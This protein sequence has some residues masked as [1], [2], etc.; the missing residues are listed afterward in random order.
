MRIL[1]RELTLSLRSLGRAWVFLLF[2]T[3]SLAVGNSTVAVAVAVAESLFSQPPGVSEPEALVD[4]TPDRPSSF[5]AGLTAD[6]LSALN[7]SLES[8]ELSASWVPIRGALLHGGEV[9]V[10]SAE[11]VSGS[12]F[13][14]LRVVPALGRPIG[15]TD[16]TPGAT[17]VAVISD[18]LWRRQFQ[19]RADVIGQPIEFMGRRF[20]VIGVTPPLFRGLFNG[21]RIAS[22]LWVPLSSLDNGAGIQSR[23]EDATGRVLWTGRLRRGATVGRARAEIGGRLSLPVPSAESGGVGGQVEDGRGWTV[24]PVASSWL[25]ATG[26]LATPAVG[27][28]VVLA[29]GG[30]VLLCA[31][32]TCLVLARCWVTRSE[33]TTRFA[34]GG[35]LARVVI[36]PIAEGALL[37]LFGACAG[38]TVT[39]VVLWFVRDQ[40][41]L[42][43]LAN[44]YSIVLPTVVSG[45]VLSAILATSLLQFLL[46]AGVPAVWAWRRLAQTSLSP[47]ARAATIWLPARGI[48]TVQLATAM[49]V[50][51]PAL[52]SRDLVAAATDFDFGVHIGGTSILRLKLDEARR[53]GLRPDELAAL[54]RSRMR[55]VPGVVSST[56]VSAVPISPGANA[57]VR[58]WTGTT[59]LVTVISVDDSTLGL[60]GV[61]RLSGRALG[62]NGPVGAAEVLVSRAASLRLFGT[63]DAT[64]KTLSYESQP[65]RADDALVAGVV[66]D[67]GLP[68]Q[69]AGLVVYRSLS[70]RPVTDLVLIARCSDRL[71]DCS[72]HVSVA[73]SSVDGAQITAVARPGWTVVSPQ[74][75]V[76]A[77]LST[78]AFVAGAIVLILGSGGITGML[79]QTVAQRTREIAV[80]VAIGASPLDVSTVVA[81]DLASALVKGIAG[82]L[83]IGLAVSIGLWQRHA[84]VH[85]GS[86]LTSVVASLFVCLS[87]LLISMVAASFVAWRIQPSAVLKD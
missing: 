54:L 81:S 9:S 60:L 41:D 72:R 84:G 16:D 13:S 20:T 80:R 46:V 74:Y 18:A 6:Q 78:T 58:S 36:R 71:S 17:P 57:S 34:L 70:Q 15:S 35:S 67:V 76:L 33:F 19:G 4:I 82:G 62:V 68:G 32:I 59:E 10:V 27:V 25:R 56:L 75:A 66:A 69:Q 21:G 64:G 61:R 14:L 49:A 40:L 26:G 11:A 1:T 28:L 45:R 38:T 2:G 39:A 42:S 23:G 73:V 3:G 31:N 29:A 47:S 22:G 51:L 44:G 87:A 5:G 24:D 7:T 77:T 50:I 65:D 86:L 85:W 63:E 55:S 52:S 12:F 83:G 8:I 48:V 43:S 30:A 79:M 37:S 53:P